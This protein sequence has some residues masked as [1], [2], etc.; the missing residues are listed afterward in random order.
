MH[1][2]YLIHK[3]FWSKPVIKSFLAGVLLFMVALTGQHYA[4]SYIDKRV[5]G[6]HVGDLILDNIPTINLDFFI[7]QGALITTLLALLL[8]LLKPK[9]LIFS[10]KALS[11][12]I[13]ARSFFI[14]LTHLG[15]NLNQITLN[16]ER[17]GFGLYEFLYHG[18]ND[19][20][21]SGHVGAPFLCALIL[22]KEK[23]WRYLF[24]VISVIFGAS[25][26]LAHM[27]YSIDI[28]AAPLITYSLYA[29]SKKIFKKDFDLI[30][31]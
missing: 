14:S 2:I 17:I 13:I 5:N 26:L 9:Y 15:V 18:K 16:T 12:F 25:M 1:N 22:W 10:I 3:H 11:L 6:T 20:F 4:Y 28:F 8:F 7:I 31:K 27:H 30:E 21:F 19:F 23:F 29:I 24:L